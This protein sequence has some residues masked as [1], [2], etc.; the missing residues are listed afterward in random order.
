VPPSKNSSPLTE[1]RNVVI[2]TKTKSL[3]RV[4]YPAYPLPLRNTAGAPGGKKTNYR[5]TRD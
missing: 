1:R 5:D 3:Q 2:G 4:T